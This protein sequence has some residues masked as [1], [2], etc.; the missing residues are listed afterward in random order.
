[1]IDFEL[2]KLLRERQAI[3]V[4]SS[5][6][7]TLLGGL[8]SAFSATYVIFHFQHRFILWWLLAV[9]FVHY[10][11]VM[12]KIRLEKQVSQHVDSIM[13]GMY[14]S[15]LSLG[16]LW[17]ILP[18]L[19]YDINNDLNYIM[20]LIAGDCAGFMIQN[21]ASRRIVQLYMIP[22]MT[23]VIAVAL[24][25]NHLVPIIIGFN[26]LFLTVLIIRGA[27]GGET[28]FLHS[29]KTAMDATKMADTIAMANAEI[30]VKN[31]A[32]EVVAN[33][34][35]V[36]RLA[37]RSNFNNEIIRLK[38]SRPTDVALVL[39]DVDRFKQINDT[40]GHS[41]GDVALIEIAARIRQLA[42]NASLIARLGGDE[43]VVMFKGPD[44]A[45][46]ARLFAEDMLALSAQPIT[47]DD[48]TIVTSV[49][50]G[51][52]HFP[53]AYGNI[54]EL[55]VCADAA[56]YEAKKNGRRQFHIFDK[57]LKDQ[58]DRNKVIEKSLEAAMDNGEV[59]AYFQPQVKL[60]TYE[61]TGFEALVRWTHPTIGQI[62]PQEI[63]AAAQAM[64][65]SQKLTSLMAHEACR[66]LAHLDECGRPNVAVAVNVSP[67]EFLSYSPA[68][69]FQEAADKYSIDPKRLEIEITEEALL[70]IKMA[71][72]GLKAIEAA[73]FKL[74]VDDFGMG[75]SSLTH[76]IG[77]N[78]N[79]LKI[80]RNFVT[81]ITENT[82]NQALV[83]TLVNL[84][85]IMDVSIVVEGV[86]S[87][88]DAETLQIL[89]C[90]V[91]QGYFISRPLSMS[92]AK[93]WIEDKYVR[94]AA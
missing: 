63:V 37:N 20:F 91:G 82:H 43:F 55:Y 13:N 86:E 40:M 44:S 60:G 18:F 41:A 92:D 46:N 51:V 68:D 87:I 28:L 12:I 54:D 59:C 45:N 69:V 66:M 94:N 27:N 53:E 11:R 75:H 57:A 23:S 39:L 71:E 84:A 93:I 52:A 35:P 8:L 4:L 50:I 83:S 30:I 78:I 81:N 47:I 42:S 34:D 22:Q 88:Q 19:T 29:H 62:S 80:D 1:M 79:C 24:F 32:L 89:G 48:K 3:S 38:D 58:M 5:S 21:L 31:S 61:L 85:R 64:Q 7:L 67:L 72:K 76:M 6:S 36:T 33:L 73:G 14:V 74:A 77:I 26:L 2:Q 70:D 25:S 17:A 65:I 9:V 56:L 16:M 49:S 15:S 10:G 90:R